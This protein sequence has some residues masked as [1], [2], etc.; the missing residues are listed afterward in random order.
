MVRPVPIPNTAVKHSLADGSGFI[1][2]ARVG[3]RQIFFSAETKVSAFFISGHILLTEI[4]PP[5]TFAPEMK[6]GITLKSVLLWFIIVLGLYLGVF[7]GLEYWNQRNGPWEVLFTSDELGNPSVIVSEP[8]LR[9]SNAKVAFSG[10]RVE[11]NLSKKVLFSHPSVTLP[12]K[13]P[14]GEV[15]Y[16][17]LRT[18]PGVVTFNFFG[19]EVELLPRVLIVNK[20]EIPW[21]PD[22]VINLAGTN[23]LAHPPKPPK[24]WDGK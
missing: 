15:I 20:R 17:D 8:R 16:E 2:S 19:H 21:K 24:G 13:M 12:L 1:D 7:Y 5:Q 23:K 6:S 3:C 4:L 18:L 22:T 11:T 9:I 14:F 10:E